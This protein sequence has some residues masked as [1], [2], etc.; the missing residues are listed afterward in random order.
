MN[1]KFHPDFRTDFVEATKFYRD[2]AGRGIAQDFIEEVILAI[3]EIKRNPERFSI[4]FGEV[5]RARLRRFH[6]YA[7][8][9]SFDSSTETLYIGSL[10]HGARNPDTGKG[11]F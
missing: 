3:R 5:R 9:Y 8:R 10:L 4:T 11:R 2:H 6:A 1:V 7:I